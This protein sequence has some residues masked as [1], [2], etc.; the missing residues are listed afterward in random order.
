MSY[1]SEIADAIGEVVALDS[2]TASYSATA[3]GTV[4]FTFTARRNRGMAQSDRMEVAAY[5]AEAELTLIATAAALGSNT[6]AVNGIITVSSVAYQVV[7][8]RNDASFTFIR[9][10]NVS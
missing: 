5:V 1:T 7:T 8:V 10:R 6:V 2:V 9:C 4:L 3:G